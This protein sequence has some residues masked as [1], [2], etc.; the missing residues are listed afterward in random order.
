MVVDNDGKHGM[1]EKKG[2][3]ALKTGYHKFSVRY[4]EAGGGKGLEVQI[5]GPT[6]K[7]QTIPSNILYNENTIK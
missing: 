4:F 1:Q 7:K 5:Q 2:E 6:L 3:V